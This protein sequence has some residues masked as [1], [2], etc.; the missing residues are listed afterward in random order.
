[1]PS[2]MSIWP[3]SLVIPAISG[4]GL[5]TAVEVSL[6]HTATNFV[7][8]SWSKASETISGLIAFPHSTSK[9]IHVPPKVSVSSV[10]RSLNFPFTKVNTL[11]PGETQLAM[12]ASMADVPEPAKMK[13]SFS[14]CI[15]CFIIET[16]SPKVF[17]YSGVR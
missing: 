5:R 10:H 12:A 6:W 9:G 13:T 1:M 17:L 2:T 14:V 16:H 15:T 11:S 3:R 7:S 4:S 8:G